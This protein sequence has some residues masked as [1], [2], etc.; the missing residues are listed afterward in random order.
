MWYHNYV[1][2]HVIS[3]DPRFQT[4]RVAIIPVFLFPSIIH[5]KKFLKHTIT[6]SYQ[7]FF[8]NFLVISYYIRLSKTATRTILLISILLYHFFYW[9]QFY[10]INQNTVMTLIF[11]QMN[12]VACF[13]WHVLYSLLFF[14]SIMSIIAIKTHHDTTKPP[15]PTQIYYMHYV[16]WCM[17]W[18]LSLW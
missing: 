12:Y 18:L 13:F 1:I 17:L 16:F 2:S 7:L 11:N 3:H 14:V 10:H 4:N 8:Y 9:Y 15:T 5:T 6:Q